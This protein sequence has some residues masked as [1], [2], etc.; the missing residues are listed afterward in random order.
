MKVTRDI[1]TVS[2]DS[3]VTTRASLGDTSM[4][5]SF[6][7]SSDRAKVV[8]YRTFNT[9]PQLLHF[10]KHNRNKYRLG[11]LGNTADGNA[12]PAPEPLGK[13]VEAARALLSTELAHLVP[14]SIT[15][16]A[17]KPIRSAEHY[18]PA[19]YRAIFG[20]TLSCRTKCSAWRP[21]ALI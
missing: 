12:R 13:M 10:L 20:Y 15:L 9:S 6:D 19:D 1:E 8:T 16:A 3:P 4:W 21:R 2:R 17:S 5:G 7:S 11:F 14:F 18:D